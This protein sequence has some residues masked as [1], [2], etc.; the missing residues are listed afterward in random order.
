MWIFW[1]C[2]KYPF[3]R[4]KGISFEF[5]Y[6]IKTA[7]EFDPNKPL[8]AKWQ[9]IP[10]VPSYTPTEHIEVA[11]KFCEVCVIFSEIDTFNSTVTGKT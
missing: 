10:R 9:A 7:R 8:S 2:H 11:K 6:T 4:V 1:K 5:L 3:K